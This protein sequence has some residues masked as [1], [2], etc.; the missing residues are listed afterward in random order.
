[1]TGRVLITIVLD[2][3]NDSYNNTSLNISLDLKDIRGI[4]LTKITNTPGYY[5]YIYDKTPKQIFSYNS[6]SSSL[7]S[8]IVSK[9]NLAKGTMFEIDTNFITRTINTKNEF[10]YRFVNFP[11]PLYNIDDEVFYDALVYFMELLVIS[12]SDNIKITNTNISG[13]PILS[14]NNMN[15]TP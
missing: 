3:I 1:M 4:D 11:G 10:I 12:S 5:L 8:D 2:T 13:T 7:I 6:S 14:L 15:F 9:I